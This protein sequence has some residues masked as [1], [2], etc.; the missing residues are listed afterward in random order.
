MS[1][2]QLTY[3]RLKE[4]FFLLVFLAF[5][6]LTY[7]QAFFGKALQHVH[8]EKCGHRFMEAL[9]EEKLGVYGSKEY[10]ES[11][12]EEKKVERD[13]KL[14]SLRTQNEIKTI[15]V[16]VHV[17]HN[18]TAEGVGANIP[19]GQIESQIRTLNEDF[20]RQNPDRTQT[21]GDFQSVAAD[22]GIE[23]VLAKQDPNGLPTTGI[24]R[25]Q[26][27]QSVYSPSD[28]A[29][30]SQTSSWPPEEYFNIWVVQLTSPIIGFAVFP[31]S[32]LPGLNFPPGIR[33]LD[34]ITVDFRYFGTGFNAVS[35][36]RGRTAT[37]EV[38]HFLGLRHIWGD[39]DCS[40]DDFVSDTPLQDGP[41]NIC[42]T[43]NPRITC[44]SRDMVENYMDY[45][46]D[47]CMNLFTLGQSERMN[48]VLENSPRRAS[49]VNN[50][51]TREPELLENDLSLR[52]IL[53]PQDFICDP[54]VIPSLV[55]LNTGNNVV[56]SA[57][58]EIRL[59]NQLIESRTFNLNLATGEFDT[60]RFNTL[61][62]SG[63]GNQ[64]TATIL[65]V[66]G[67]QDPNPSNNTLTS[68]PVLQGQISLPYNLDLQDVGNS[69]IIRNPDDSFTWEV[70]NNQFIDGSVRPLIRIRNYE[71][72]ANGQLDFLISPQIN[73][74]EFPNAQLV[75]RMAHAP[76]AAQGFSDA[77]YVAIST[78]CG[79]TFSIIDAP[80]AKN[81]Q[82]L[83][84]VNPI[85]DEF[86]ANSDAQFRTEIVNLAPFADLG[87]VRIAFINQNGF[88]NNI[89]LK[90]IQILTEETFRYRVDMPRLVAPS[91]IT[92]NNYENEQLEITNTGNLPVTGF[93]LRR[94]YGNAPL[95]S[96][97]FRGQIAPGA[98]AILNLPKTT[99]NGTQNF[100]FSL[101]NPSFDQNPGNSSSLSRFV[102]IDT[103]TQR[104][105][106]R[107]NFDNIVTLSPW[108]TINPENN[109][110]AWILTPV[111]NAPNSNVVRAQATA[112]GNSFW[113]GTPIFELN[114]SPQ[115]ALFFDRAAGPMP[116]TAVLRVLGSETGG[117]TYREVLTLR[118]SE[119]STV[120]SGEPN[121]NNPN[122][123]RRTFVNLSEFAGR[124]KTTTRVA[125]VLE[126]I[127]PEDGPVFLNNAE[128]FISANPE[129]VDPGVGN[130][131]LYPNPARNQFNLAFNL[132]N[133]EMVNIKMISPTGALVHDVDYPNTLNQTYSFTTQMLSK[134]LFIIQISSPTITETKKLY[135]H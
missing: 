3:F 65:T 32:D 104:T 60:L 122:D 69:W 115:G 9:L 97:L 46:T 133:F 93:I 92:N 13:S 127:N 126:G 57:T 24:V 77:L 120:T 111:Q 68:T 100:Q 107:Q 70:V 49:L 72:D 129:P 61:E 121:P 101:E 27:T 52:A 38:G 95:N 23:F 34:G 112:P 35:T 99:L 36:S 45:T 130:V 102:V 79:N 80:Y 12:L 109:N 76:F 2:R 44:D 10:F 134:G 25:V 98:S 33:E 113:L 56:N 128:L 108:V 75:F 91:P 41:N 114:R 86:E 103:E 40:V 116:S 105:P 62:L 94:R 5:S 90:D 74:S 132:R 20:R 48:I 118:G 28:A 63:V 37:H 1:Q 43:I 58:A 26:G 96:F 83:Q 53:E 88:G 106:W 73:L 124:G 66:N 71:Y 18:G 85:L 15:P 4:L 117:G 31:V 22:T 59:N 8:D 87:S 54:V 64:F 17:I 81:V 125:I 123:F 67:S 21:P 14:Q 55:V 29:L 131:R 30:I 82:F 89:F 135:I 78:D 84:T 42:R 11:W 19:W 7:S 47:A 119:I 50:R 110:P 6:N 51:A 16:V 39:G